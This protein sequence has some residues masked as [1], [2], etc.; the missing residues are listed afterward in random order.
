MHIAKSDWVVRDVSMEIARTLVEQYHY[1]GGASNT[2]TYL[3]GLFPVGSFWE[4]DCAGVA[5]WIPPTKSA[6]FATYPDNWEGVLA[7]SRLVIAPGMPT[8]S[9]TFL[10]SHSRRLIDSK[11]WPCL[12][13][14]A[15]QWRGHTGQIYK[16]DNWDYMGM[17]GAQA[18]YTLNG[19]MVARKAGPT[20]RTH[21]E[22]LAMGCVFEGRHAKHK[23]IR[24]AARE[25]P[26]KVGG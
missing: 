1:A 12:V 3:H 14:Y 7:L 22:M 11:R 15:D 25:C 8:N 4:S 9:A 20:T 13:T 16:A 2:S 10:L 26:K 17:T 19:R 18:T 24:I 5:W 23:F 21:V 6:A